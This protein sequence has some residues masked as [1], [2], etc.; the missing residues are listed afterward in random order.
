MTAA[1]HVLFSL[2]QQSES[3]SGGRASLESP[4]PICSPTFG[5]QA[6]GIKVH[7]LL[8]LCAAHQEP[9]HSL[10]WKEGVGLCDLGERGG[11]LTVWAHGE[12]AWSLGHQGLCSGGR[13]LALAR[14]G[15]ES[16]SKG[17]VSV[18]RSH[19][20]ESGPLQ[21]TI[22]FKILNKR[23]QKLKKQNV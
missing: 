20:N 12:A 6:V 3:P 5:L 10:S 19:G 4:A 13:C 23:T 9:G 1:G 11:L 17:Q 18:I 15:S 22:C 14:K 7:P 16:R 21:K 2:C 8:T